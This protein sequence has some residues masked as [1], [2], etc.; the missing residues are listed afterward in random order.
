[1]TISG[2]ALLPIENAGDDGVGIVDCKTAYQRHRV[3]VGAHWRGAATRHIEI[4]LGKSAAA[5]PQCQV[6]AI[7]IFVDGNNHLFEQ[8]T[9]QL[10]FVACRRGRRPPY[11][12][13]IAAKSEQTTSLV[14]AEHSGTAL[15]ASRQLRFG[16]LQFAQQLLPFG[17]EPACDQTVIR[18][19]SAITALGALRF[20]ACALDREAPLGQ[21]PIM[22]GLDPHGGGQGSFDAQW[23]EC[24][25]HGLRHRV[26]DLDGADV[27]AV[28]AASILN[29]FAGAVITRRGGAAGVVGAQPASA[30]S[31]DGKTLQQGGSLSHGT[32]ARLM[33]TRM[34]IGADAG[35][36]GLI[37]APVDEALMVV[38][39]EHRPLRLR[40]LAHALLARTATIES[41]LVAALAI[42]V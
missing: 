22:I 10:F 39:D 28:E 32:A 42:D 21:R 24:R 27:K 8:S 35:A 34:R 2:G 4:D 15:F 41:D 19:D 40:Q 26:V 23:R 29:P 9:Q 36:I 38:W 6:R 17:F 25:Q 1:M 16:S 11:L 20:I 37:G 12:P 5:P 18:I 3:F 33:G 30:V 31:A 14:S 7:L 13:Q